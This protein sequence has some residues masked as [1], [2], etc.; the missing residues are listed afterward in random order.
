M[1]VNIR[2]LKQIVFAGIVTTALAVFAAQR[3]VSIIG[4]S[5]NSTGSSSKI[6]TL[7]NGSTV[8]V[9]YTI[10]CYNNGSP[11]A[12]LT[13]V[14]QT[15]PAKMTKNYG[16][17]QCANGAAA[18]T[19]ELSPA[20]GVHRCDNVPYAQR[21]TACASGYTVCSFPQATAGLVNPAN[22]GWS[23]A[24]VEAGAP[25]NNS[26]SGSFELSDEWVGNFTG[27]V[28]SSGAVAIF[29]PGPLKK[30]KNGGTVIDHCRSADATGYYKVMCCPQAGTAF[31]AVD[32]CEVSI[33]SSEAGFLQSPQFKGGSPF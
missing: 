25:F 3:K 8:P 23:Y 18:D 31:G 1:K 27:T 13:S 5:S 22:T 32:N 14:A 33:N 24:W 4:A 10:S 15:L 29:T 21:N 2:L 28:N 9:N 7:Q 17:T 19:Y 26:A 6:I 20:S 11:V 30:C 12:S 16:Q